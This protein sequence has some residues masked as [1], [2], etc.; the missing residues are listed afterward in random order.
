M[1]E[2]NE[3]K[4]DRDDDCKLQTSV[5]G[6]NQMCVFCVVCHLLLRD[7]HNSS[8]SE[9]D[10]NKYIDAICSKTVKGLA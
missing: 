2:L 7:V 4:H 5:G 1:N 3:R 9:H 10:G 8:S 6:V